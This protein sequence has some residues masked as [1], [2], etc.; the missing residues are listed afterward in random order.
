MVGSDAIRPICPDMQSVL[1]SVLGAVTI[2]ISRF[3]MQKTE[4]ATSTKKKF[5]GYRWPRFEGTSR[6]WCFRPRGGYGLHRIYGGCERMVS[7][8]R[9]PKEKKKVWSNRDMQITSETVGK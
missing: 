7:E 5:V 4:G 3:D 2:S 8:I 1:N 9:L 6:Q